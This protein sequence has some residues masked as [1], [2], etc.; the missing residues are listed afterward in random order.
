M[1][2]IPRLLLALPLLALFGAE[3]AELDTRSTV[4]VAPTP[5]AA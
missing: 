5:S 1:S 2:S 4:I 3:A